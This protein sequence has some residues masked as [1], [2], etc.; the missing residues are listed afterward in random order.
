MRGCEREFD[1]DGKKRRGKRGMSGGGS[2]YIILLSMH[3][4]L[5]HDLG[6]MAKQNARV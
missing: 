6:Y 2:G 3:I 5:A 1:G 4:Y